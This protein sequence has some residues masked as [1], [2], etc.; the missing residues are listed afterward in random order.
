M[1]K[2]FTRESDGDAE[3]DL[4]RLAEVLPRGVK[5]YVTP[6]GA[7]RLRQELRDLLDAERPPVVA[8]LA[9]GEREARRL[10]EKLD[11]RISLLRDRVASMEVVDPGSQSRD[12]VRFGAR[13][14]VVDPQGAERTYHIVGVDESNPSTGKVSFLSPIARALL[15]KKE[16]DLVSVELPDGH[17]QLEVAEIRY[18]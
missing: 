11:R 15:G 4:P 12:R 2:A 17:V 13:V 5:N 14:T 7:A 8:A 18:G 6:E 10:L 1:S 16:R 3:D 9:T